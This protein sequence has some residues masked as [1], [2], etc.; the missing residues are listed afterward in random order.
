MNTPCRI[1]TARL[2]TKQHRAAVVALV[3]EYRRGPFGDGIGLDSD[4]A[5]RLVRGLRSHPG[6]RVY[7]ALVDGAVVGC[8]T[9]FT[10][11]STFAARALLNIHDLIV[12]RRF[13][14]RG[15]ARALVR[16]IAADAAARGYCKVTLEVRS[17][18][19]PALALYAD[20]GFG[21][22]RHLMYF[23]TKAIP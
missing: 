8:A 18:N 3:D 6:A 13:R 21:P 14:R 20:E 5:A 7:L 9:C 2:T 19:E 10:G 4:D 16:R 17:D 1:I 23:L 11:F 15:I 12:T 22:G